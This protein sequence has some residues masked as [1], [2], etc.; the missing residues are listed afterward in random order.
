MERRGREIA[1]LLRNATE[2][3]FACTCDA[4]YWKCRVARK[5]AKIA[6]VATLI[7][8]TR[9]GLTLLQKKNNVFHE[10]FSAIFSA[11]MMRWLLRVDFHRVLGTPAI[12][13]KS[14]V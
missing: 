8:A 9:Q 3:A 5:T 14:L 2:R 10:N 13:I 4:I 1:V 7:Q 12:E 11:V 6:L